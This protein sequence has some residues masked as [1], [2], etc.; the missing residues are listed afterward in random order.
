M[1]F[2]GIDR[3]PSYGVQYRTQQLVGVVAEI[4]CE[5]EFDRGGTKYL[6]RR[7]RLISI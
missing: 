5:K 1:T 6:F 4:E 2:L 3:M 7:D